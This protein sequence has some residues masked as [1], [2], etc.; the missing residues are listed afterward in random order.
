MTKLQTIYILDTT[1]NKSHEEMEDLKNKVEELSDFKC[2][3]ASHDD[4][5]VNQH[6]ITSL[7]TEYLCKKGQ[8]SNLN[9][10]VTGTSINS[11]GFKYLI[12][13][14]S[15]M[16]DDYKKMFSANEKKEPLWVQKQKSKK[17]RNIKR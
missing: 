1:N 13:R 5:G 12:N 10:V 7:Q 9:V 16:E 6:T 11:E 4:I 8:L 14:Y 17:L 2:I 15:E 3:I